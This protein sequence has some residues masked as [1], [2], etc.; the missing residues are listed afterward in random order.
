MYFTTKWRRK[1]TL[2]LI[3]LYITNATALEFESGIAPFGRTVAVARTH[4]AGKCSTLTSHTV[5][6]LPGTVTRSR[7]ELRCA[8]FDYLG[9]QRHLA[10]AFTDDALDGIRVGDI[11]DALPALKKSLI[12]TYGQPSISTRW[13]DYFASAGVLLDIAAGELSFASGSTR[14]N[15]ESA[16]L[17][18][19]NHPVKLRLSRAQ[20]GEDL[21]ALDSRIRNAHVNPFWHR[22]EAMYAEL[23]YDADKYI[24]TARRID[25]MIVNGHFEKLVAHISDGHS[26][27]VDKAARFGLYPYELEWFGDGLFIIATTHDRRHLL[28]AQIIAIDDQP[29]ARARELITP[30]IPVVNSSGFKSQSRDAFRSDGLLY[31]AGISKQVGSTTL[32]LNLHGGGIIRQ[33]YVRRRVAAQKLVELGEL[34]GVAIP[35][36]RQHRPTDQWFAL[37]DGVLYI[38]Y[39]SAVEKHPGDIATLSERVTGMIDSGLARKVIVD[40]RDNGGG[41]SHHNAPLVEALRRGGKLNERGKLFV[42]TNHHTF[43]AAVNFA[44]NMEARTRAIFIGEKVGDSANFAGESG[45]QALY[46]LPHSNIALS[47]SFSEWSST[48]DDDRHDAVRLDLPVLTG[49]DDILFGRDPV[50]QAALDYPATPAPVPAADRSVLRRWI[51]RYDYSADKALNIVE[52]GGILRMELTESVFSRLHIGANGVAHADLA[53]IGLRMLPTGGLE[54]LQEG[55]ANRTLPRLSDECLKPLELLM[56]GRF[57]EAKAAYRAAYESH[58]TLLS[59]RANSLGVLASQLRARYHSQQ[60]Y[61]QLREIAVD[62]HGHSLLSWDE[63]D[64]ND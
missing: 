18:M 63:E 12:R 38:R 8:G 26:Y 40:V 54:L 52:D 34:Q 55:N 16:V 23:F 47:L 20:W 5:A 32:T 53:G 62:L 43:S 15:Q 24:R 57:A 10:L 19:K 28:G 33:K 22:A 1:S 35:M 60:L 14:M 25:S 6:R 13:V 36:Y 3:L 2:A 37:I 58:P 51:G 41:D 31:A 17:A 48:Y 44:G 61:R 27:I 29:I 30:Y 59:I 39:A 46:Q 49:I 7:I 45:P 64:G 21:A 9:A 11:R 56:V 50:L 42:L 4:L